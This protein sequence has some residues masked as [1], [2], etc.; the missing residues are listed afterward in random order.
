[1]L[2]SN[3]NKSNENNKNSFSSNR[4][5]SNYEYSLA[6]SKCNERLEKLKNQ[7]HF[8]LG[9]RNYINN[10]VDY[11]N[12]M[13]PLRKPVEPNPMLYAYQF[14]PPPLPT[15]QRKPKMTMPVSMQQAQNGLYMMQMRQPNQKGYTGDEMRMF[16]EGLNNMNFNDFNQ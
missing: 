5:G 7:K 13:W 9:K 3:Y 10:L 8:M 15:V 12:F 2:N 11:R 4:L 6:I 16:I 1:M 14:L